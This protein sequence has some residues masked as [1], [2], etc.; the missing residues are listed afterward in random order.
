MKR[1]MIGGVGVMLAALLGGCSSSPNE[2]LYEHIAELEELRQDQEQP[3]STA[4]TKTN[5]TAYG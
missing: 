4:A 3:T 2:E 5:D 1:L